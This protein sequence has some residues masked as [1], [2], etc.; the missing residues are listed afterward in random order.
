MSETIICSKLFWPFLQPIDGLPMNSNDVGAGS[1]E[2]TAQGEGAVRADSLALNAFDASL[3]SLVDNPRET[4]D[5]EV[6]RWIDLSRKDDQA[7][8]AKAAIALANHGGGYI[9]LGFEE[10]RDGTF[11]VHRPYPPS[12]DGFSQDQIARII[13][14]YAEPPF[15]VEVFHQARQADGAVHPIVKVPGGHRT[16]IMAKKGSPDQKT[17]ISSKVYIRRPGPESAEPGISG[18]WRDLLDR[19]VRAGRDDLLDAIRGVLDGGRAEASPSAPTNLERIKAWSDEGLARW[20]ELAPPTQIDEPTDPPGRYLVAYQL[21]GALPVRQQ[22]EV[23]ELL[24][25][26]PGHTGWPPWWVPTRD[27]IRPYPTNGLIECYMGNEHGKRTSDPAHADF[28]RASVHG[29]MLLIRGLDEDSYPER[30]VPGKYF[31]LTLPVWRI[32]ECLLH[33]SDYASRFADEPREVTFFVIWSG[34]SGR[35]LTHLSGRRMVNPDRISRQDSI[36]VSLTVQSDKIAD[37]LPELLYT[38]L[39]PVYALF[40]F[41]DLPKKLVDEEVQRLR[42]G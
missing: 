33:A 4:L 28:W 10:L 17:L 9:V 3:S 16:P 40:D 14:T 8:L 13:S 22:G 36:E 31:D 15:Q 23:L 39:R 24:R 21:E 12:L 34:L 25:G 38:L 30:S 11:G 20:K 35:E 5:I 26:I 41:F 32:G 27:G 19:C 7:I 6:K 42:T 1:A 2:R 29:Q 18:D 37:Q